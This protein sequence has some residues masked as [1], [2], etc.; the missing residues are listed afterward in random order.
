MASWLALLLTTRRIH[1]GAENYGHAVE[2]CKDAI[3]LNREN[4]KAH[5]RGAQ[6]SIKLRKWEQALE[7]IASGLEVRAL[8]HPCSTVVNCGKEIAFEFCV[9]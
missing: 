7:F 2:D 9:S 1:P 8:W 5:Y 4:I 6:A 3:K